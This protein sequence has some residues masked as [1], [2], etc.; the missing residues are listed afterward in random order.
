MIQTIQNNKVTSSCEDFSGLGSGYV[1][2]T[3][4]DAMNIINTVFVPFLNT[5]LVQFLV[6]GVVLLPVQ[7]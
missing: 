6:G 3:L 5:K 2:T 7:D 4:E 1:G